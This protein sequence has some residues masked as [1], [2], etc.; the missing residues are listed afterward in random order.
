METQIF[1]HQSPPSR[2]ENP[3]FPFS[4]FP[5]LKKNRKGKSI[6][7]P[8]YNEWENISWEEGEENQMKRSRRDYGFLAGR[9]NRRK[10]SQ[11]TVKARVRNAAL[12]QKCVDS[13]K[14][15]SA[16]GG[17]SLPFADT[18][19]GSVGGVER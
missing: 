12:E 18:E 5:L 13:C 17:F 10:K 16:A 14:S 6:N 8:L 1:H 15:Q 19:N 11:A 2:G 4:F 9:K 3:S 7:F